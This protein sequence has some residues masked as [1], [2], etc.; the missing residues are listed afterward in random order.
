MTRTESALTKN[1]SAVILEWLLLFVT[2]IYLICQCVYQ[3]TYV[4][5]A[6]TFPDRPVF[7]LILSTAAVLAL[8]KTILNGL[9]N[10]R[11]IFLALTAVVFF[12][13]Y[14]TG[15]ELFLLMIPVLMAGTAGMDYGKALI[16]YAVSVGSFL[17]VTI[18]CSFTGV[19]P[20][21]IFAG[22]GHFRSSWG[23]AYPTDFASLVLFFVM[24]LWLAWEKMP[25]GLAVLSAALS[26]WVALSIAE[27]RTSALCGLMFLAFI[28]YQL[29]LSSIQP[30]KSVWSKLDRGVQLL[31][32]FSFVIFAAIYFIAVLLYA[33]GTEIGVAFDR[34]FSYRLYLTLKILRDQGIS[35]F[36]SN[37]PQVGLGGITIQ[38]EAYY[39]LDSSYAMLLI[40]YGW[41]LFVTTA[42]LCTGMGIRA[43]RAG[44]RKLLCVMTV[45]A[46]H[47]MSEH[48]FPEIQYNMLMALPFAAIPL[49]K[50]P[51]VREK[52]ISERIRD[53]W[54]AVCCGAAL[55]L[56]TV[57]ATPVGLSR[58]RTVFD[59]WGTGSTWGEF[60]AV[61]WCAILLLAAGTA[62]GTLCRLAARCQKRQ[63]PS[64]K[65][66]VVLALSL[67][68]LIGV[69]LTDSHTIRTADESGQILPE[70]AEALERLLHSA[71]GKVV[72][73]EEPELIRRNYPGISRSV[74]YG[75][76]LARQENLSVIVNL[77]EDGIVFS[78]QGFQFTQ[79]S[80]DEAIYSNDP[81]AIEGLTEA[82]YEWTAYDTAVRNVDLEAFAEFNELETTDQGSI[83]LKNGQKLRHGPYLDFYTGTYRITFDLKSDTDVKSDEALGSV[84]VATL[85]G[86][87]LAEETI[88]PESLNEDGTCS[89]QLVFDTA[90]TRYLQFPI[91]PVAGQN[92]EVTGIHYQRIG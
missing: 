44:N 26:L 51:I 43:Y 23:I 36:G 84:Y 11:T 58:L 20:N 34:L 79:I 42:M 17:A 28:L 69:I 21:I 18:L 67:A 12:L 5:P 39:F 89:L 47:A 19:I 8:G 46:F 83:V 50:E 7:Q 74:W 3:S 81:S 85:D 25:A 55:L 14:R 24:M 53:N 63:R 4:L 6:Y 61:L 30:A 37:Y 49:Q 35:A 70:K 78:R 88:E 66:P 32:G 15:R 59:I 65:T 41:V 75:Q 62:A 64:R 86:K 92:I 22:N 38:S 33:K 56:T 29:V 40:R 31:M 91:F 77:E 10:V 45:I 82:G 87:S 90:D 80:H 60:R 68:V 57:L 54:A 52:R 16:F 13:A 1:K 27:S 9:W 73:N 71:S 2:G 72:A 48:H 76:E